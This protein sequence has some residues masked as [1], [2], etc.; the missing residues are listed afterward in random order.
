MT[1]QPFYVIITKTFQ[2]VQQ[3]IYCT[4]DIHGDPR[5]LKHFIILNN[6]THDDLIVVLGDAGLNYYGNDKGDAGR[7]KNLNKLGVPVLCIH[8][9]HEMRPESLDSYSE[10]EWHGGTVY[11]EEEFP[12]ILFAKDGEIY[13]IDGLSHI[14]LGGAYSVDKFYRL[15]N[16]AKWFS[17]EQPS[18]EIKDRVKKQIRLC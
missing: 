5:P 17:D 10:T 14:A 6:L 2:E 11:Y 9:N 12:N 8:D 4:G 1:F 7:K 15:A 13:D 3:L 16:G 18:D